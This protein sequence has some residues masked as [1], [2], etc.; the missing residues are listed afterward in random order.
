MTHGDLV[1]RRVRFTRYLGKLL[2]F[3]A[4][5][6]ICVAVDETRRSR[7][8]AQANAASGAGIANS[9]HTLG[10]AVDLVIFRPRPDGSWQYLDQGTEPEYATLA[11]A[12]KAMD[13]ECAWGGDFIH[14]P[15]YDHYSLMTDGV[16]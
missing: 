7:A 14:R 2:D 5:E 16:R 13:P 15:D 3:A 4:D 9:L 12:W 8:A 10:L 6:A 1:A 11:V